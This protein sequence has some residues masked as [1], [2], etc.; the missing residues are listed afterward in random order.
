[1]SDIISDRMVPLFLSKMID[2]QFHPR[3]QHF[4]TTNLI[5]HDQYSTIS[6]AELSILNRFSESSICF[7]FIIR[8]L[9]I[10]HRIKN[11]FLFM[12]LN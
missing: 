10:Y 8:L 7:I 12:S 11:Y 6:N 5:S 1:M 3:C 9:I 2:L 4:G